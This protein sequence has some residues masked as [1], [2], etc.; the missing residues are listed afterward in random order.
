MSLAGPPLEVLSK[1]DPKLALE[2]AKI[3]NDGMA[4]LV[5]K[6]PDHFPAFIAQTPLTA[7]DAGVA[8]TERAIKQ[9]GAVGTQIYTHVGGK[10]IDRSGIRAVLR[11]H[12]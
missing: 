11:R 7:P 5:A 8:E 2:Y 1:G 9:L 3:G 12:E 6:H 10:P 4:E